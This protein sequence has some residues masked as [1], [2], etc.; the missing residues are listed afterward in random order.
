MLCSASQTKRM[1]RH[2]LVERIRALILPSSPAIYVHDI[3]QPKTGV[4][5]R[6][7]PKLYQVDKKTS[8][9][10]IE[11]SR[12]QRQPVGELNLQSSALYAR[13]FKR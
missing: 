5:S 13:R 12:H 3:E 4:L 10:G 8:A 11:P 7:E 9:F 1:A 6:P 2:P